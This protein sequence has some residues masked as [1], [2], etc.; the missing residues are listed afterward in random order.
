MKRRWLVLFVWWGCFVSTD[1]RGVEAVAVAPGW[2]VHTAIGFSA[3]SAGAIAAYPFDYVK[4][5]LQTEEGRS[6]Y[7]EGGWQAATDIC[8][9]QGGPLALYRGLV[10]NL[11]GLAPE[12]TIKLGTND[13][14][15]PILQPTLG[16]WGEVLAGA[17]AGLAQ[18]TITNP[19]EV[20][21]VRLQTSSMTVSETIQNLCSQKKSVLATLY[22]GVDACG[23]RDAS[24]SAI[25]FPLYSHTKTFLEGAA[26]HHDEK[27]ALL[28]FG[29]HLVAGSLAAAPAAFLVTPADVIKTRLQQSRNDQQASVPL[30]T[31]PSREEQKSKYETTP[32]AGTSVV[33]LTNIGN[34]KTKE[35]VK[36][37]TQLF[38][39]RPIEVDDDV[40]QAE[41]RPTNF[42]SMFRSVLQNEGIEVLFSGCLERVVRSV[43]QFGITLAVF[44]GLNGLAIEHGW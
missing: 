22:E 4:S 40:A 3:G 8:A 19:L 31:S 11:V 32:G 13:F 6:K 9:N 38:S 43:P 17:C 41:Q 34:N 2:L 28:F 5:V 12:K 23:V 37:S 10:V 36:R 15:R 44:D 24:F 25:L 26:N 20:V 27:N 39:R 1:R 7:P 14:L 35:G 30:P 33:S 18:V 21:K 16:I 42:V 29:A